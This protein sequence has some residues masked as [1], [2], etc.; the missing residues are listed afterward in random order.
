L[1]LLRLASAAMKNAHVPYSNFR[2]GAAIKSSNNKYYFGCNV[3]NAAYPQGLCAEAGALSSMVAN[4]C[5][6]ISEVL[7]VSEGEQLIVPCG[8]CRQKLLEFSNLET[9]VFL[10]DKLGIQQK[11]A[12]T[13]LLPCSFDNSYLNR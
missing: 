11:M 8:G 9:I 5:T 6:V 12:L 7:V 1:T 4:G 3:E 10:A 13:E 2:V